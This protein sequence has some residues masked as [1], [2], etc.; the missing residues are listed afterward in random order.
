M[1]NVKVFGAIFVLVLLS[2]ITFVVLHH[3]KTPEYIEHEGVKIKYS[4]YLNAKKLHEGEL[5][6]D[7][8]SVDTER[9]IRFTNLGE[10][11][12]VMEGGS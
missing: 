7:V 3:E 4:D 9:C 8:C 5:F 1:D 6:F 12:K 11:K 2:A 10:V